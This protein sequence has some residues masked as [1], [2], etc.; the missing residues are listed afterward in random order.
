MKE[1]G[2]AWLGEVPAHWEIMPAKYVIEARAGGTAIKGQ[3]CDSPGNG[4]YQ[5][6]SASGPD[7]WLT[8]FDHSRPGLVLSAVGARCGKVFK[9][10]GKWGTVANTHCLFPK[11][12]A[13]R[14]YLWY[15][16][17]REE[18]WEKGGTAQ[19]FVKVWETLQRQIAVPPVSEQQEISSYLDK[20]AGEALS[21]RKEAA[22]FINLLQERR[23][24]LISAA[25]T[26][27]IDLRKVGEDQAQA[28]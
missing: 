4:L 7:V 14:D 9:A 28:A 24:A 2:F 23:S 10:D 22:R 11:H 20:F 17:N 12:G 8:S 16:L 5:G 26:G 19:P 1:S 3:C 18:W 27:K 21:L 15:L 6:Y 25:V 13:D